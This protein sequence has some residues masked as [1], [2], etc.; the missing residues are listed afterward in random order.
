M[1]AQDWIGGVVSGGIG[2]QVFNAAAGWWRDRRTAPARAVDASFTHAEQALAMMTRIA[3]AESAR[4][5]RAEAAN[6]RLRVEL[7]R[8][9]QEFDAAREALA[10]V[11]DQLASLHT[12]QPPGG[13]Q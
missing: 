1:S 11:R 10:I 6:E 3:D 7:D 4:A 13:T 9:E 5:E 8:I 12:P 2:T